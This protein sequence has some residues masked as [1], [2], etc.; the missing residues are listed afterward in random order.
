MIAPLP[1]HLE[2][3]PTKLFEYMAV[4]LPIVATNT[5]LYRAVVERRECGLCAPYDDVNAIADTIEKIYKDAELR[6]F[7]AS[8]GPAAVAQNYNWNSEKNILLNFIERY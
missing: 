6:K 5:S 7:Y 3:Y 1:N 2:S 4:G 8:N